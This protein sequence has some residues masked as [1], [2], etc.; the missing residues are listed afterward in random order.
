MHVIVAHRR[1][2]FFKIFSK[3][4]C[5]INNQIIFRSSTIDLKLAISINI[6][7]YK[8]KTILVSGFHFPLSVVLNVYTE[9]SV[10]IYIFLSIKS[11]LKIL[12]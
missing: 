7:I 4:L 5:A 10:A 9:N 11:F 2:S 8:I 3:F 6:K 12:I 1:L